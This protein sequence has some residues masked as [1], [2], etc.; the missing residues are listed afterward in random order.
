MGGA[1]GVKLVRGPFVQLSP[2][3]RAC[4][5]EAQ[6]LEAYADRDAG[7]PLAV[8]LFCGAGGLSLGLE[9]AGFE[10]VL[11]VDTDEEA[12][13]THRALCPGL[14]VDWDLSDP[15]T[16]DRVARI[17]SDLGVTLVA[18]G[19]PC[20]P[21]SKAGRSMLRH[22][23][24]DG[25][26]DAQDHRR[27][28]WQSLL[29]VVIRARPPALL[30]ENVP[31]MVLD[32]DMLVLRT[33]V[34]ELERA[35]YA[36]EV[37]LVDTWRYGVPQF[38]QR[39]ILVA[40]RDGTRFTWPDEVADQV[41][42]HD[43]I[44]DLPEV[45][46]GWRPEDGAEGWHAYSGPSSPFQVRMRRAVI[47]EDRQRVFDH[48]TRP[49]RDDDARAFAVMD[50]STRYSD[51]PQ[52]L[53]RYRDDIFDDKYKR[54]DWGDFSRT[55]TAHIA[56][57]GYWYIHPEQ[58]RTITIREAARLQTF[59]DHVRFS[60]P[61]TAAFRQIGNAVPPRLAEAVGGAVRHSLENPVLQELST[62]KTGAHLAQWMV[63]RHRDGRVGSPWHEL[64]VPGLLTD[65]TPS[66]GER[67][68][69][70]LSQTLFDRVPLDHARRLWPTVIEQLPDPGATLDAEEPLRAIARVLGRESRVDQVLT[71][72]D[73]LV[74]DNRLLLDSESF[75]E[76]A[77]VSRALARMVFRLVP[78]DSHDPIEAPNPVLRVAAR[79]WGVDVDVRNKR[80]DGRLAVARLVSVDDEAAT[81]P[82]QGRQGALAHLALFEIAAHICR[83]AAPE[84]GLCPLNTRCQTRAALDSGQQ[85]LTG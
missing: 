8:D 59:P 15:R 23:V 74:H 35:N 80:S 63:D 47:E 39:L 81:D 28:L 17:V 37:R 5:T 49:V 3:E 31:D 51:L 16:I 12:L 11:G 69:A 62:R 9:A 30:M 33:M 38:R 7:R 60:G 72:A 29:G 18:G 68:A 26:R 48:I 21:F 76:A 77:G 55:I 45:E 82:L 42:V 85:V 70:F 36:V 41:S 61:P 53:K 54:L 44:G 52:E 64:A 25:K 67:W 50:P 43:A 73:G 34:D 32:R 1:Y 65:R 56:K 27:E 84:C 13:G 14:S 6:L 57:D 75:E 79:F 19:P 78:G 10:V 83:P 40:L 22:L 4:T 71:A 66:I 2:H 24:A 58:D 20:Q 46:G